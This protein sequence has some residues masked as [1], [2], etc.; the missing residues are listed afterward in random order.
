[1]A[2]NVEH[3]ENSFTWETF[4]N[5][6]P[7]LGT[8]KLEIPGRVKMMTQKLDLTNWVKIDRTYASQQREK[9]RLLQTKKD[10]VFVTNKDPS[11]ISAKQEL[12]ELLCDYLPKRFPDKF[13]AR[14]QGVYNKM[15]DEFVSSN[16]DENDDPLFKASRLTQEDWCIM[17]WK[18]E[19]QAYC[20]TAGTVFF[21]MRWGLQQKFNLPMKSIHQPVKGFI[22]HLVPKV[23]DLFKAMSPDAPVYRGNWAI[24]HD[25]DGPLDLYTPTGHDD[26]NNENS[27]YLYQGEKTGRDLTFRAEYQT[28]RKLEKS[29]AIVFSIRTYQMY[30]EDFKKFPR[31]ETEILIKAIENLHPD[32]VLYKA[33]PFW[34]DAALKYL[35]GD[36]LG[37][38]ATYGRWKDIALIVG[39]G[40]TVLGVALLVAWKYRRLTTA[41]TV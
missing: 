33:M 8:F 13:E 31:R 35:K 15:L 36:V 28:L 1:M 6:L 19:H 40:V 10:K 11:T 26:R 2:I 38:E 39:S 41:G 25:L 32:F 5:G 20:L 22:N 34:K 16:A 29:T 24:F 3:V 17:E 21:P 18:E 14:E 37:S 27:D 9:Q 4:E 30:L 12:L 23:Y 7:Y